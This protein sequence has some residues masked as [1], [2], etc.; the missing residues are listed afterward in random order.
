MFCVNNLQLAVCRKVATFCLAYFLSHDV[1]DTV[2]Q[3]QSHA[4]ATRHLS[5]IIVIIIITG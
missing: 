1:A 2:I 4:A 5:V 3:T